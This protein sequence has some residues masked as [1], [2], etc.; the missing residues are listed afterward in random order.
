M[1]LKLFN[2]M[3]STKEIKIHNT[4]GM[5]ACNMIEPGQLESKFSGVEKHHFN[6][7]YNTILIN[8][9]CTNDCLYH[10][11][12]NSDLNADHTKYTIHTRT[13]IGQYIN[14]ID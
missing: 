1:E 14:F 7:I 2:I 8:T 12:L 13:Y 11:V 5:S 9:T 3:F 6:N 4:T 10:Q